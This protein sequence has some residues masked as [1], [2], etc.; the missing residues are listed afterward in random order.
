[1]TLEDEGY[2]DISKLY[3]R[4]MVWDLL[5][6]DQANIFLPKMGLTA[7][8]EEG[9]ETEHAASH[10]RINRLLPMADVL[11]VTTGIAGQIV[12]RAILDSQ[13]EDVGTGED[14]PHLEH[15][16][17]VIHQGAVAIIANLIDQGVLRIGGSY[18]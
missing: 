8:S 13:G 9:F 5:P 3:A 6:C 11:S 10:R 12:G 18:E 14:H 17:A 1:M 7:A 16:S 4:N 2:V 15:Y